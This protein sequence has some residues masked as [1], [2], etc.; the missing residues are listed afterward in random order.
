[1][2]RKIERGLASPWS[3]GGDITV[4]GWKFTRFCGGMHDFGAST[5]GNPEFPAVLP[6]KSPEILSFPVSRAKNIVIFKKNAGELQFPTVPREISSSGCGRH[7]GWRYFLC[8][9]SAR[10]EGNYG[11]CGEAA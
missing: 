3:S 2:G 11:S 6:G 4:S 10:R 7:R 9:A 1:M 5:G 8:D